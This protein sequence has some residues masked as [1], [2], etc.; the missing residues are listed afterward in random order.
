M[1]CR[2]NFLYSGEQ[3]VIMADYSLL[4]T[5]QTVE[6]VAMCM[7]WKLTVDSHQGVVA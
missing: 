3:Q 6:Y 1:V 7:H 4:K 2:G 5:E